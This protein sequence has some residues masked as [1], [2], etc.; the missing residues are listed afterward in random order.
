MAYR[1]LPL[2]LCLSVVG[3]RNDRS[4]Q[5][6][7]VEGFTLL[8]AG[9]SGIDFAN[10][11][12]E[13]DSLNY[14]T[15]PY[16]FLGNGVAA[17]DFDRDGRTD[18]FFT[19]AQG[20]NRLYRNLGNF[21][22]ENITAAAGLAEADLW[23]T[24]V[25]TL[26][27]NADGWM[28]LYVCVAGP[29]A[30]RRN[31]LY[32]NRTD[33]TFREAAAEYGLDDNA[34]SIQATALDYDGD[35]LVDLLVA[36]YANVPV[37]QGNE[38]YGDRM[39]INAP[40]ESIHL[41]RNTGRDTFI[42]VTQSAG[43]QRFS[44]ALGVVAQD[45]NGDGLPDL[46]ISNDF[47]VP[48]YFFVNRGDGTFRE[49]LAASFPHTSMFGMGIDAG[50][51]NHDGRPDL[52]QLDMTAADYRRAKTNMASMRPEA[53]YR[54]V[55]LG[56]HYQYMQNTLQLNRGN[57]PQ[58]RPHFSDLAQLSG[59][60]TTDWS[61]GSLLA[62]LD[63]DGH[64]DLFI[65]NGI[66][67]DVNNNDVN[68]GFRSGSFFGGSAARDYR[69]L[70]SRPI[71][72]FCFRHPGTVP[73]P[74]EQVQSAWGLDQPGFSQGFVAADLDNDGD[75]D[76][77]LNNMDAPAGVY[78]NEAA[79]NYMKVSLTGTPSDP[80]ALNARVQVFT[81]DTV[82][83]AELTLTR[84]Y[85][86]A[87]PRE[88]HF[89]LG[90]RAVVDS[91]V[92]RWR[93]GS[94]STIASPS[95]NQLV[96]VTYGG[97]RIERVP[98]VSAPPPFADITALT[99]LDFSHQE[100]DFDDFLYQPLLPHRYSRLGPGMAVGDVNGDGL[101][102]LF[103]GGARQQNS[104]LYLQTIDGTFAPAGPG[105][106]FADTEREVTGALFFDADG[107]GDD[108][109]YVVNGGNDRLQSAATLQDRL[110]V[111]TPA[112]LVGAPD[113]LPGLAGSGQAVAASDFDG[114]GDID[115]FVGGRLVPGRYPHSPTSHLLLNEGGTVDAPRFR[116]VTTER[117]PALSGAGLITSAT[118]ADVDADG[119]PDLITAG[120]W[121]PVTVYH[122]RA[123]GSF[124]PRPPA[125]DRTGWYYALA[126]A[127]VD[128]D[129][130]IDL[131]A[132]NLGRNYKYRADDTHSFEVYANDFDANGREDIV[133]SKSDGSTQL[134]LRGR[135]CSAQQIP[136]ITKRF[137][138][139][140]AFADA[141]L[142]DIYGEGL[143][144]ALHYVARDFGHQWFENDGSGRFRV[145]H[146]PASTQLSSINSITP[147]DYN[148]D[149][150]PDFLLAGNLLHA[151]VETTRNDAGYG[152]ILLGGPDGPRATVAPHDS[153][154][155]L[156][157]EVRSVP[158]LNI[159][160]RPALLIARNGLPPVVY[161]RQPLN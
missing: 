12:R 41:Y 149:A 154:L 22:F 82:Q 63:N 89:G 2:I 65:T 143:E 19:A 151:E 136:A 52:V 97:D 93:D 129:G 70:P 76:L 142:Q 161:A 152:D 29:G 61:W 96:T 50:D 32:V 108:D 83:I 103:C 56:F 155:W 73:A 116:D 90:D 147:L 68:A 44:L 13:S 16:L 159:R 139:Y 1:I 79:G 46:Y 122:Q 156:Y 150:Y 4:A 23:A 87:Q 7:R 91:I 49:E 77:V 3:C 84:G 130:D 8:S 117:C 109:L 71:A 133:L 140:S 158:A 36:N 11:I 9:E 25:T 132:G 24:G 17:A 59:V 72:N 102:D 48:D 98:D 104:Q 81:G 67:R 113:A 14:F 141:D 64:R 33:G 112:G 127:D 75:L 126:A 134:P 37:S 123:D 115:L 43:L 57:D 66:K 55:E 101:D 131:L 107:D 28:D 94:S 69:L 5:P 62:D 6:A 34:H 128:Q 74:F 138:T 160:D 137:T 85:L 27:I 45:F 92:V 146:L 58:G 40:V 10:N 54:A 125:P 35:G 95:A 119:R 148:G 39:R 99:G 80:L 78:R 31:R 106:Q 88:L 15:Y 38:F 30:D 42:D 144:S 121:T 153:G 51:L 135:E 105:Y 21:T 114:D 60:A 118:W 86:S 20:E 18:L 145:H 53:F 100:D 110:Y 47:N 26:D 120:E 124:E 111:N 157:G